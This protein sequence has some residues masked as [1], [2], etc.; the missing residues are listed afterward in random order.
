MTSKY[1]VWLVALVVQGLLWPGLE[2]QNILKKTHSLWE[3]SRP[4]FSEL[5]PP[6]L[7]SL[8]KPG[9]DKY[10]QLLLTWELRLALAGEILQT[11]IINTFSPSRPTSWSAAARNLNHLSF[12]TS[13]NGSSHYLDPPVRTQLT[14]LNR[15]ELNWTVKKVM[16]RISWFS[17][18][19]LF[20]CPHVSHCLMSRVTTTTITI[21]TITNHNLLLLFI[22]ILC[23]SSYWLFL[24][25]QNPTRPAPTS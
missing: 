3:K 20:W 1:D 8:Q 11:I 13:C 4:A 10:L 25:S 16:S 15:T 18:K 6:L 24:W 19:N 12:S 2:W 21:R 17:R 22:N 14:E 5:E 7:L 9:F 23:Q